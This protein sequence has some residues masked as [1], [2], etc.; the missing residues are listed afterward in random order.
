MLQVWALNRFILMRSS[1]V[2]GVSTVGGRV[3]SVLGGVIS[4]AIAGGAG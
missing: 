3:R 1:V 2:W 4:G